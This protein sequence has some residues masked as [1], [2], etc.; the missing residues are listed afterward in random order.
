MTRFIALLLLPFVG[1]SAVAAEKPNV[2]VILTDDQGWGDL[3]IHGNT[4]LKTPNLDS[5]AKDGAS[6]SHFYVQPVCSPTRAEF[7]T[8]RYHLRG[9]VRNVTSGGERLN[10]D[11]KTIADTFKA[12]GY[13]TACFGKWHNGSQYPYHPNGR[14]FDEYYGFTSGHWGDYYSP[15]LEHNDKDVRGEG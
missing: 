2:V 4:N 9:G 5:L 10:L 15:P 8:G 1:M 14:G 11:E 12:G 3:S 7:L 6:F 13:S